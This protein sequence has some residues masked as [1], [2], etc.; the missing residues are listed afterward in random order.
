[1]YVPP[2]NSLLKAIGL[3]R[4]EFE[5]SAEVHIPTELFKLLL[6][7][8]IANSDFNTKGYLKANPDVAD[9]VR[10]RPIKISEFT[11][12]VLASL[13]VVV[14]LRLT[15]MRLGIFARTPMLLMV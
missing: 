13:K 7:I 15:W 3:N 5:R 11:T 10:N 9:A 4:A 2:F 14:A 8:A 1:M 6:Q 12:S